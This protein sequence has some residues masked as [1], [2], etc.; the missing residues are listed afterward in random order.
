[1]TVP[2]TEKMASAKL[3]QFLDS[4]LQAAEETV[5]S[6]TGQLASLTSHMTSEVQSEAHQVSLHLFA[7][8]EFGCCSSSADAVL[9]NAACLLF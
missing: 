1:M 7:S 3:Q 6:I 9:M 5:H 4:G 2:S 8:L